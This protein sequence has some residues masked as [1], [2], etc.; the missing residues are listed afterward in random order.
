MPDDFQP[1]PKM[2]A[3]RLPWPNR[4]DIVLLT[5]FA[6]V[7]AYCDRVNISVAAPLIM[8]DYRWDTA[9]MGW[10]LS[11]FFIGYAVFMVPFG[12]LADRCGPKRVLAWSVA[13]W[14]AFT[15]L[16]PIPKSFPGMT[17]IRVLIGTGESGMF[18]SMNSMLVRWFPREEYSRATGFGWSGG[19]AGPVLAFPLSSA[20]V[21]RWGWK[22]VFFLF[23]SLGLFWLPF[24]LK[25][26]SDKP[27]LSRTINQAELEYIARSRPEVTPVRTVPWRRML[28]MPPLW[29]TLALHFSCNWYYYMMLSWLPTYLLLERRI[30]FAN[31]G[32]VTSLPFL[33]ALV[34]TNLSGPLVDRLS[35]GRDRT[36][37]RKGFLLPF[38]LAAC[39]LLALSFTSSPTRVILL[40]SLGMALYSAVTPVYSS[41]SLDIAPRYAG[42][43]VGIQNTVANLAGVAAPVVIG[44]VVKAAGWSACFWLT[45]AVSSVGILSFLAFG[46]A[47]KMID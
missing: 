46:S 36:R 30:S 40:L 28:L 12:I 29:A 33:S 20:I 26:S 31:V 37:V 11:G 5:F 27:E 17:C 2:R 15:A 21:G 18:P 3:R 42:V 47:D 35:C 41:S 24:W 38:G 45:A 16:T 23:A 1:S 8:R 7:V 19:Y 39:T 13:W 22:A 44:Y 9:R 32:L 43:F 6:I 34:G 14:S 10:V 25:A 4:V